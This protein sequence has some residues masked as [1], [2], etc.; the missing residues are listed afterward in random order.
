MPARPAA[1][2]RVV[3]LAIGLLAGKARI[4][5]AAETITL[6]QALERADAENPEI[7]AAVAE[8]R[9]AE[10]R[11][12]GAATIPYNPELGVGLGPSFVGPAF[13]G[14][15]TTLYAYEASLSQRLELGG[16]RSKR[17]S[18]A[19][20]QQEAARLRLDWTRWRVQAQARRA[21]RLAIVARERL[22]TT[23]Q[24]QAVARELVD[25]ARQRVELGAGTQLELNVAVATEGRARQE[26]RVA[27]Q[28][29][30]QARAELAAAMAAP[31][32]AELE[33]VGGLPQIAAPAIGEPE[34]VARALQRRGDVAADQR[35]VD[36]ARAR[37]DLAR[38]QAVPDVSLGVTYGR[39]AVDAA[40]N[41]LFGVS[42][43]IPLWNRNQ[44]GRIE[45][46]ADLARAETVAD[47]A[48]R[49]AE[50]DA[51]TAYGNFGQASE[52]VAG[53]DRDV[54]ERLAQNL[55]LARESFRSG[56]IGLLVFNVVRRD[57]VETR[58]AYL[59]ALAGLVEAGYALEL[60][61]GGSVE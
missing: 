26:Q 6:D 58:L 23:E 53:F 40:N 46:G 14:G 20:S 55:E 48:R 25:A 3:V 10:G 2:V 61:S 12:V 16:K 38:A 35:E 49:E 44:G 41:V 45:A 13:E 56:K 52:A 18:A 32:G 42:I 11:R 27:A 37:R 30:R 51:R 7:K 50:R 39:D 57:L 47:A 5:T 15:K 31:A 59:D 29:L 19:L 9:A 24:G 54:I 17:T 36:A 21:Y 4:A 8:L 60:A 43:P 22:A 34:F 33:P 1:A 28:R